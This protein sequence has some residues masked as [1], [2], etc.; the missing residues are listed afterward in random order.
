MR[1]FF[2]VL[3]VDMVA[4]LLRLIDGILL[5]FY[6]GVIGFSAFYVFTS[7]YGFMRGLAE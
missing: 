5:G 6:I 1:K 4:G 2:S 7:L 3:F